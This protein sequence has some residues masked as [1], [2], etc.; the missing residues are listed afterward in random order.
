MSDFDTERVSRAVAAALVGPGGVALVV[1]VF[2]GLPGVIH[3]PARRGFFGLIPSESRS[4]T[5]VTR[6]PTTAGCSLPTW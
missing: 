3:T 5:G 1:K 2:A 4:V 6:S